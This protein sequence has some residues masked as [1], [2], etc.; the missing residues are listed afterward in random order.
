M[1]KFKDF[2]LQN[3]D[4]LGD[5]MPSQKVWHNINKNLH[6]NQLEKEIKKDTTA[7]KKGT[8]LFLAKWAAAACIFAL[9]GIGVWHILINNKVNEPSIGQV[10][11]TPNNNIQKNETTPQSV[12]EIDSPFN[13]IDIVRGVENVVAKN[14]E[15]KKIIP[16]KP[17]YISPLTA[18]QKQEMNS[19]ENNFNTI[20]TLA[21]NKIANTP[22]YGEGVSFYNDFIDKFKQMEKDEKLVKK[23]IIQFGLNDML[24]EQLINIYQQ[25]LNVLKLL[26]SEINKTNI[27]YKQN[28]NAV[29]T[30]K[31]NYLE[32]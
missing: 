25:K 20:I 29:D 32:I 28:R 16:N 14:N 3:I 12:A 11:T 21:K 15:T 18:L 1:D 17:A 2:L 9:A 8:L 22:I 4:D 30:L 19:V 10:V 23:E 13:K 7:Q 26:Q 6:P 31:A 27:R 24:L 5:D